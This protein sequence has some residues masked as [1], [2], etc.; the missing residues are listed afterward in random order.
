MALALSICAP[1]AGASPPCFGLAFWEAMPGPMRVP[2]FD[3]VAV[4][5]RDQ[6]VVLGGFTDRMEAT[7][8]I[9]I[10]HPI[11]G[12][13]P[14]GSA[15]IE[16]RAR[17]T[18][19]PLERN[20][21]LILG[22]YSGVWSQDARALDDG[23][24]LDPL[25]AGSA[26]LIESFGAPL[27][28]HSATP[29]PDGRIAVAC[30]C[31]LRLFDPRTE[32]W[33]DPIELLRERRHHAAL[34]VG[35]T[36]VLAGGVGE[37]SV[38]SI[39]LDREPLVSVAWDSDLG[40]AIG[41]AEGIAVDGRH[42]LLAGGLA[43]EERVTLGCTYL[44]D[45]AKRIVRPGPRLPLERGACDL[46]LVR[47]P[48]GMLILDGEWRA[49]DERGN[50]NAALLLTGLS[51]VEGD[52]TQI[53]SNARVWRLPGPDDANALAR[54]MLIVRRD[55]SVEAVGGYRFVAPERALPGEPAGVVVDGSGQRLVVDALPAAD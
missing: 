41:Y 21:V 25:V 34:V 30:G 45:V 3:A 44:L 7:R 52:G 10:R 20:R 40:A 28:G 26:R 55:G 49:A 42:G 8:A 22:G 54:R 2:V 23:E 37:A 12:W 24:T 32:S 53:A 19:I 13:L 4:E 43:S 1:L 17:A 48:R 15:L 16:P 35:R 38:E 11:D 50:A 5:S 18:L 33:S 31:D 47:H 29:L 39:D 14:V 36:L 6:L 46:T 9:Q 27:D 51:G